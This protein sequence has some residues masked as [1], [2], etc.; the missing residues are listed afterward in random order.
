MLEV[1]DHPFFFATQ[2]HPELSARLNRP[3]GPFV[4]FISAAAKQLDS[5]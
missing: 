5:K 2:F 4:A 3:S 1:K